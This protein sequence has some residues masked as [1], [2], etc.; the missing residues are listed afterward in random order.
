MSTSSLCVFENRSVHILCLLACGRKGAPLLLD[1]GVSLEESV[2]EWLCTAA[3]SGLSVPPHTHFPLLL[4]QHYQQHHY[5][6]GLSS[7]FLSLARTA[8][9]L[10]LL[11][12]CLR[13]LPACSVIGRWHGSMPLPD[14]ASCADYCLLMFQCTHP[15]THTPPPCL[16]C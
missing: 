12:N 2:A 5:N 3:G 10:P 7:P 16:R 1:N 9:W 15:P 8:L 11:G 6:L 13:I 14:P 4:L